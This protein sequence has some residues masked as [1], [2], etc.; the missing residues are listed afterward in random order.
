MRRQRSFHWHAVLILTAICLVCTVHTVAP[1]G[2]EGAPE[3]EPLLDRATQALRSGQGPQAGR[4]LMD[5]LVDTTLDDMQLLRAA[6]LAQEAE[7]GTSCAEVR[8]QAKARLDKAQADAT[9]PA[10]GVRAAAVAHGYACLGTAIGYWRRKTMGSSIPLLFDEASANAKRGAA[11]AKNTADPIAD[12]AALLAARVHAAQGQFVAAAS[13]LQGRL[14]DASATPSAWTP[15]LGLSAARVGYRLGSTL[16]AA[17]DGGANPAAT[18]HLQRAAKAFSTYIAQV[19][20][21]PFSQRK[22]RE[23]LARHAWTLHRLGAIAPARQAY[24]RLYAYDP[25]GATWALKG[26]ASLFGNDPSGH[27][28]ALRALATGT[29]AS[30]GAAW[31]AL[32]EHYLGT[33]KHEHALAAAHERMKTF[34][35]HASACVQLARVQEARGN[36]DEALAQLEQALHLAPGDSQA[37][38]TFDKIARSSLASDPAACSAAYERLL[39]ACPDNPYVR[40]NYAFAL[41]EMLTPITTQDEEEVQRLR[42]DAGPKGRALLDKC[43]ATYAAAVA[44]I[45]PELDGLR[46]P[47]EDWDLAGIVNDY[48]VILQYFVEVRDPPRAEA[49]YMRALRMTDDGYADTYT[50]NL[51]RLYRFLLTDQTWRWYQL[52]TRAQHAILKR[53]TD[54]Q[55]GTTLVADDTKRKLAAEDAARLNAK[56]LGA[57]GAPLSPEGDDEG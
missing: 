26:L 16:P 18:E 46:D 45:D 33:G 30:S 22:R 25:E 1:A 41:R 47:Q 56:L 28:R 24:E 37:I 31:G 49:L 42:P 10:A 6:F 2:A 5:A 4:V 44:L 54:P 17:G 35:A 7:D 55:R 36:R 48:A 50:P 23:L 9:Q 32:A 15:L 53:E 11:V 39:A 12:L 52:A 34:A 29:G 27:E 40:N 3:A 43:L 51:R 19:N 13:A 8:N 57:L 38:A 21:L 20:T 14:A